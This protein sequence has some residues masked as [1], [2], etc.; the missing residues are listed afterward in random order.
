MRKFLQSNLRLNFIYRPLSQVS[1]EFWGPDV[2]LSVLEVVWQT[3]CDVFGIPTNFSLGARCVQYMGNFTNWKE[4]SLLIFV[5][6]VSFIPCW[7]ICNFMN[8]SILP[9]F[10]LTL[11]PPHWTPFFQLRGSIRGE[12]TSNWRGDIDINQGG[13]LVDHTKNGRKNWARWC[14]ILLVVVFFCQNLP[15][16][17]YFAI[18]GAIFGPSKIPLPAIL[19]WGGSNIPRPFSQVGSIRGGGRVIWFDWMI[20][21]HLFHCQSVS[22]LR[23]GMQ[24][25]HV[26]CVSSS[27]AQTS[28]TLPSPQFYFVGG[29]FW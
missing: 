19:N 13:V 26:S 1:K 22:L 15:K 18:F 5:H 4:V 8:S 17:P 20:V 3:G 25:S 9:C 6:Q 27:S 12:G 21:C 29:G 23:W 7:F 16:L 28:W 14:K 2:S 11:G 10:S 24:N